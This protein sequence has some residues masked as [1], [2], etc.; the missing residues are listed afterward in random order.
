MKKFILI[1]LFVL[2]GLLP[3]ACNTSNKSATTTAG[4]DS[5][6]TSAVR[7]NISADRSLND[8]KIEVVTDNAVVSRPAI[9]RGK[10]SPRVRTRIFLV[11]DV[12][13]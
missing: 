9:T 8:T 12:R 13:R 4:E 2:V 5:R 3:F 7:A 10:T 1:F 6:I 11:P